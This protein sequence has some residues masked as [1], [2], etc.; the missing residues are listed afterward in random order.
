LLANPEEVSGTASLLN[1]FSVGF[2]DIGESVINQTDLRQSLLLSL[3]NDF[4]DLDSLASINL[5]EQMALYDSYGPEKLM[6]LQVIGT[7]IAEI[8]TSLASYLRSPRPLYRL[9]MTE[10]SEEFNDGLAAF[11]IAAENAEERQRAA[12]LNTM[13]IGAVGTATRLM[14][15]K[16][17]LDEGTA[18]I[19]ALRSELGTVLEQQ[20]QA[21]TKRQTVLE[22]DA[23]HLPPF[24]GLTR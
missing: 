7:E 23:A 12:Q 11:S 5:S 17:S 14:D 21:P 13:F 3:E 24:P 1:E 8:K 2:I 6:H 16:D 15:L 9:H 22:K 10:H 20:V 18:E 4:D 19:L